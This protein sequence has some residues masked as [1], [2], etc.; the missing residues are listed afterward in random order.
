M[1]EVKLGSGDRQLASKKNMPL[2]PLRTVLFPEGILPLRIFE[3]RYV[4]MIR[5]CMRENSPFGVVL[6][7]SGSDVMK[8]AG[9]EDQGPAVPDIFGFGTQ[10]EIVDFNQA[11]NG[12][13]GIIAQGGRKFSVESTTQQPDGLLRGQVTL[14]PEE[15]K[16]EMRD[17]YA[18]LVGV[19]KDLM[20]HPLIQQLNLNVDMQQARSV[21]YRLAELLPIEPEIKQALLQLNRPAERMA[22]LQRLVEK[23]CQQ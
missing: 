20:E 21:S 6:L 15:P 13:L 19:L 16:G 11:D 4:D 18:P 1:A 22:E 5:W 12:L 7:K 17:D 2:F 8:A 9:Q 10:A 23:F 3:P 14:V